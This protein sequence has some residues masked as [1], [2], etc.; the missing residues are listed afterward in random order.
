M[1]DGWRNGSPTATAIRTDLI[2]NLLFTFKK[3]SILDHHWVKDCNLYNPEP[4]SEY[5]SSESCQTVS[6]FDDNRSYF[7]HRD[8]DLV[9]DPD[10]NVGS[11]LD[12]NSFN[13]SNPSPNGYIHSHHRLFELDGTTNYEN[14]SSLKLVFELLYDFQTISDEDIQSLKTQTMKL[15]S[16]YT[17][18][19]TSDIRT[20]TVN[21]PFM[22]DKQ[23][24]KD[25]E[26]CHSFPRS[27][28]DWCL[29]L[30]MNDSKYKE[31][32]KTHIDVNFIPSF[33][34]I[35]ELIRQLNKWFVFSI[36]SGPL[37]G[38]I[39]YDY[40]S[41][42]EIAC[43]SPLDETGT[44]YHR[45]K[46]EYTKHSCIWGLLDCHCSGSTNKCLKA[47]NEGP[48][49]SWYGFEEGKIQH[50]GTCNTLAERIDKINDME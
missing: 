24:F 27:Y 16:R 11:K 1:D 5:V 15:I 31:D 10:G 38:K 42:A 33:N 8:Y 26:W 48:H 29:S 50:L 17:S 39:N 34:K 49:R 4:S 21:S 22:G 30:D 32:V 18:I 12:N 6:R 2:E 23:R 40:Q 45:K 9:I 43:F 28:T 3:V 44:D 14:Q 35:T 13:C 36:S 20:L 47:E 41:N 25:E 7:F 46:L 19:E 37:V